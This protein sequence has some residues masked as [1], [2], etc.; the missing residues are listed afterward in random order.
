MLLHSLQGSNRG[1][2]NWCHAHS[3]SGSSCIQS[4]HAACEVI[5]GWGPYSRTYG[6]ALTRQ[7]HPQ[8]PFLDSPCCV[9]FG[10]DPASCLTDHKG[11]HVACPCMSAPSHL[12]L[13]ATTAHR[14]R[15]PF[16]SSPPD[17]HPGGRVC[18]HHLP[19]PPGGCLHGLG[20][21]LAPSSLAE[22]CDETHHIVGKRRGHCVQQLT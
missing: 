8:G 17:S 22:Q 21:R 1:R 10:M 15:S 7:R 11:V 20:R 18:I 2:G 5:Q 9:P 14:H 13:D 19:N 4:R 6:A 3:M 12:C 16:H